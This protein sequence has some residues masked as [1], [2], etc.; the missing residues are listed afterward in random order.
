MRCLEPPLLAVDR[1]VCRRARLSGER[2][3]GQRDDDLG[4][5]PAPRRPGAL[6]E[7]EAAEGEQADEAEDAGHGECDAERERRLRCRMPA[8]ARIP[9][10]RMWRNW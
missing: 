4:L 2:R 10:A 1:G 8:A 7:R 9:P 6:R 3:R 5:R